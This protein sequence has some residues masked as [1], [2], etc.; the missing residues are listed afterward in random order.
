MHGRARA[1]G[2]MQRPA[3]Y[4]SPEA[5]GK[6]S[7][8]ER[9]TLGGRVMMPPS[10]P[11]AVV[12]APTLGTTRNPTWHRARAATPAA[13]LMAP[14]HLLGSAVMAVERSSSAH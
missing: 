12:S 6:A 2:R 14:L 8:A 13:R 5:S 7:M 3:E 1:A 10:S 4:S 11:M 9:G